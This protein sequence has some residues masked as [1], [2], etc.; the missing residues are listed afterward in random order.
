MCVTVYK[1]ST[2]LFLYTVTHIKNLVLFYSCKV[3]WASD[4]CERNIHLK[5]KFLSILN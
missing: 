4:T 3:F 2:L 1:K 5:V